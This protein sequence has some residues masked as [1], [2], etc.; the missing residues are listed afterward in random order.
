MFVCVAIVQ[1][2]SMDRFDTTRNTK[3]HGYTTNQPAAGAGEEVVLVCMCRLGFV[4]SLMK[5]HDISTINNFGFLIYFTSGFSLLCFP[6]S[7]SSSLLLLL[8]IWVEVLL[9]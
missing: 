9:L 6:E 7:L 3:K 8:L 4:F 2:F 5:C 1:W